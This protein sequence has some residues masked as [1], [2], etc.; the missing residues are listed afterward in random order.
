MASD[1]TN[2]VCVPCGITQIVKLPAVIAASIIPVMM[3]PLFCFNLIWLEIVVYNASGI[4][5]KGC[6]FWF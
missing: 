4:W 6:V 3:M 1:T 5:Q 2:F